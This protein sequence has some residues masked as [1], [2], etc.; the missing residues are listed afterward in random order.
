M[1]SSPDHNIVTYNRLL[2]STPEHTDVASLNTS[3]VSTLLRTYPISRDSDVVSGTLTDLEL[4]RAARETHVYPRRWWVLFMLCISLIQCGNNWTTFSVCFNETQELYG[5]SKRQVDMLI[6][7]SPILF[8]PT[9]LFVP[10]LNKIFTFRAL[11][12][13]S[14]FL[15]CMATVMRSFPPESNFILILAHCA[16][17]LNAI[18]A[19]LIFATPQQLSAVWF[20]P[21]QRSTSTSIGVVS[22]YMGLFVSYVIAYSCV[23]NQSHHRLLTVLRLEAVFSLLFFITVLS[24]QIWYEDIP[25]IPPSVS[26]M[27][28]LEKHALSQQLTLKQEIILV[29]R[30]GRFHYFTCICG[31]YQGVISGWMSILDIIFGPQYIGFSETYAAWLG[32]YSV[33][34]IS[35][36]GVIFGSISDKLH[37]RFRPIML[38]LLGISGAFLVLFTMI[39]DGGQ[40]DF[41]ENNK[42]S[43]Q[44]A[45]VFCVIGIF[46][47]AGTYGLSYEASV[48]LIYPIRGI[49]AGTILTIYFNVFS[50]IFIVLNSYISPLYMNWLVASLQIIA[51]VLLLCHHQEYRRLDY[52]DIKSRTFIRSSTH[53]GVSSHGINDELLKPLNEPHQHHNTT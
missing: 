51:F 28:S 20:P 12:T 18:A 37:K 49:F 13:I 40:S 11:I 31:M 32:I 14:N 24:D 38:V 22:G 7:W 15:M 39:V 41:I 42:M 34:A 2:A 43:K 52:D 48:E 33:L 27:V 4:H 21:S 47:N 6:A 29:L 46:C 45:I 19:P 26:A 50:S 1:A 3:D 16:Q 8:I 5:W 44:I 23:I 30:N 10:Y 17:I 9:A 53:L 25:A 36:S 35:S